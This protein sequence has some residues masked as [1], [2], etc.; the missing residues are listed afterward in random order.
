V[1]TEV[2]GYGAIVLLL[3]VLLQPFFF[4]CSTLSTQQNTLSSS[5]S[6]GRTSTSTLLVSM[7]LRECGVLTLLTTQTLRFSQEEI[8][9]NFSWT[10]SLT[11]TSEE[12]CRKESCDT[13]FRSQLYLFTHQPVLVSGEFVPI[14][15]AVLLN[16]MCTES[17]L[18]FLVRW[19]SWNL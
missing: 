17:L 16:R 3:M 6:S 11:G 5:T 10:H 8:F 19:I 4:P 13:F 15:F 14:H 2:L 12:M 9:E 18:P 7:I 1:L